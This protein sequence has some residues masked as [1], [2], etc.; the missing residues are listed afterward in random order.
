MQISSRH[1]FRFSIS[2]FVFIFLCKT[3]FAQ[4]SITDATGLFINGETVIITGSNFGNHPDNNKEKEY[5]VAAWENLE[6]GKANK[7]ILSANTG[8]ELVSDPKSQRNNSNF[9]ARGY[10][11]RSSRTYTNVFGETKTDSKMYGLGYNS[12]GQNIA[13]ISGWFMFPPGFQ[14][15]ISYQGEFDQTKFLMLSPLKDQ[16]KTYYSVTAPAI[17]LRL[18]TEEGILGKNLEPLSF[19]SPEGEW[20]RFD[21]YVDISKPRGQK[22]HRWYVDGQ[23]LRNDTYCESSG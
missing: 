14:K 19:Y 17:K 6:A 4:P 23:L 16:P 9:C 18:N 15:N 13:F 11:W 5:V 8:P 10:R 21:I 1:I 3:A 12:S 7:S 2:L 22:I 20:H